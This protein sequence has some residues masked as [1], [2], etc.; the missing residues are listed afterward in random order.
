MAKISIRNILLAGAC[1]VAMVSP[2][3]AQQAADTT[4]SDEIIVTAQNRAQNIQDVPI[5]MSVLTGEELVESGVNDFASISRIAPSVNI[6]ADTTQTRVSIRGIGSNSNDETQDQAVSVN[7]DG[8]YINRPTV[9][10]SALFDLDRV[11]VLR[12]PQGTLYGRNATGGAINFIMRKPGQDFGANGSISY[13]NFD[14]VTMQGGVDIPLGSVAAIRASGLYST[15]DGYNIH[16]NTNTRSGDEN[17]KAG[18]LSLRLEPTSGL[19]INAAVEHIKTKEIVPAQAWVNLTSAA[20]APGTGC[21]NTGWVDIAPLIAGGQCAP[22]STNN[23]VS[24]DRHK[25]N[26]PTNGVGSNNATQTAVRGSLVYDFGPAT[27]TYRAGYRKTE[28]DGATTL[29]PAYRFMN[30]QSDVESQSHEVR[31]NGETGPLVWQTGG[32][33]FKEDQVINR[34]LFNGSLPAFLLGAKGGYINYFRRPFVNTDSKALFGQADI[35]L[36]ETLTAVVGIRYTDDKRVA[37]Y[38]NLGSGLPGPARNPAL[39]DSGPVPVTAPATAAQTLNLSTQADKVTWTAGLNFKPN[40][41]TLIYGKVATGFKA[42]GFDA[43]GTY[44]PE[45]NTSYEVGAKL[46]FGSSG[47]HTFNVAGFYNDYK[48]LQVSVLIDN[49]KGGQIFNAGKAVIYGLE[50]EAVFKLSDSDTMS[51]SLNYVNAEYKEL[52]A[53]IP[54][55]CVGCNP[56]VTAVADLDTD[57]ATITQPNLA[58]N[59]PPITPRVTITVGY[60]KEFDLGNAGSLTAS[61]FSTYKSAYYND[62]FNFRDSLQKSFTQTDLSLTWAPQNKKYNVQAY[63]RNIEDT[64]PVTY[65]GFT[66][67]GNDRI[68]NWQ[69][70]APRTY[71][72]RLSVDF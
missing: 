63:V 56:T 66:A 71:G 67:A 38:E 9:L 65:A 52:L 37:R 59:R 2:A 26:S 23:L 6:V 1:G 12:G 46:N 40:A 64:R 36:G 21:V 49:A 8:E 72:V 53:Q 61:V 32:F 45:T 68:Y 47:Q 39:F 20:F 29:S 50:A 18:R 7:I 57:P 11:E 16:P 70:A 5:A 24:I 30:F 35:G 17:T 31:L 27:F 55:Y 22:V 62:I 28:R 44:A 42:G 69:F 19:T 43:A 54:V 33:I 60:D 58:G 4:D 10:N 25:Y 41:D 48:D 3:M 13:G 15:R 51:A 14:Q 34:G